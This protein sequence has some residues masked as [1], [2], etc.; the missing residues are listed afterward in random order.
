[1][2]FYNNDIM[3]MSYDID[4]RMMSITIDIIMMSHNIDI[5]IMSCLPLQ[6]RAV[7]RDPDRLQSDQQ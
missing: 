3:M 2:M 7:H 1:M 6:D 4:I 5:L